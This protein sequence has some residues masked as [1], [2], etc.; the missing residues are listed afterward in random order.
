MRLDHLVADKLE[1]KAGES[2]CSF[3]VLRLPLPQ[4]ASKLG[5]SGIRH[6]A[7]LVRREHVWACMPLFAF[8]MTSVILCVDNI[9]IFSG[10]RT[11]GQD[12][13]SQQQGISR[14]NDHNDAEVEK[15][16]VYHY[17]ENIEDGTRWSQSRAQA[18]SVQGRPAI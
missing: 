17:Y 8:H 13:Q 15:S 11:T 14:Q 9:R 5:Q 3:R 12:K 4:T 2:V 16:I 7:Y 10:I 6:T 18:G 1:C